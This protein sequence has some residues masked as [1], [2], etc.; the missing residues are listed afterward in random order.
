VKPVDGPAEQRSGGGGCFQIA[1]EM[2]IAEI[3]VASP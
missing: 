3:G 2:G 1:V